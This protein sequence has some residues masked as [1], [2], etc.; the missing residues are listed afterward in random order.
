MSGWFAWIFLTISYIAGYHAGEIREPSTVK[1]ESRNFS[2]FLTWLPAA[3]NPSFVTYTVQYALYPT[4]KTIWSQVRGCENITRTECNFTCALKKN[5][6]LNYK[7]RVRTVFPSKSSWVTIPDIQYMFKV[8]PDSPYLTVTKGDGFI[9]IDDSTQKPSCIPPIIYQMSLAYTLVIR[10]KDNPEEDIFKGIAVEFPFTFETLGYDGEYCVAAKTIRKVNTTESTFS[11]PICLNFTKKDG[12]FHMAFLALLPICGTAVIVF[13]V[14][15]YKIKVT[16]KKPEA[17]DFSNNKYCQKKPCLPDLYSEIC[18]SF[19]IYNIEQGPSTKFLLLD[20][21]DDDVNSYP[22]SGKGYMVRS[23]LE[24]SGSPSSREYFSSKS[25]G[26]NSSS[27]KSSSD[28]TC[29]NTSGSA[30]DMLFKAESNQTNNSPEQININ[31]PDVQ[32]FFSTP[33]SVSNPID[34][35]SIQEPH[36]FV[37]VP[38]STLCIRGNNDHMDTSDGES[39]NQCFTDSEDGLDSLSIE[40]RMSDSENLSQEKKTHKDLSSDY[41]QRTY[42]SRRY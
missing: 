21:S 26:C 13:V 33:V 37:N 15:W 28:S 31:V 17:L 5:V 16:S 12:Y 8:E 3:E 20:K 4:E 32:M 30:K 10:K 42:M 1:L 36:S 9:K 27:D 38:F 39:S 22:K 35:L 18:H 11:Q 19:T 6:H 29:P 14:I 40:L 34:G 41:S 7:V 2:L 23:T 24:T 25:L